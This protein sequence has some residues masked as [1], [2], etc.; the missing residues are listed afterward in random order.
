[1]KYL[2]KYYYY[3]YKYL[4]LLQIVYCRYCIFNDSS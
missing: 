2:Y 3:L 4:M 1:M